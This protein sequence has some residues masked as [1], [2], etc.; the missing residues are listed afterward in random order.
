M[1]TIAKNCRRVPLSEMPTVTP[2]SLAN[3]AMKTP[4]VITIDIIRPVPKMLVI[5]LHRFIFLSRFQE[6]QLYQDIY[7]HCGSCRVVGFRSR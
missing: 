3:K 1:I 5:V 2:T 7:L 4:P 6:L